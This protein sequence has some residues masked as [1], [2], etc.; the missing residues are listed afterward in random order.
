[1]HLFSSNDSKVFCKK[2]MAR[3]PNNKK[4]YY[5]SQ[6]PKVSYS[7]N[8][9]CSYNKMTMTCH[10][11]LCQNQDFNELQAQYRDCNF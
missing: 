2:T 10:S 6:R 7:C 11:P 8:N 1:M 3:N 5:W 4:Q 9:S